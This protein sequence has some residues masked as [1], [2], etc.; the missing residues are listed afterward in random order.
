MNSIQNILLK[1]RTKH[2]YYNNIHNQLFRRKN[3][4]IKKGRPTFLSEFEPRS[5]VLN[6]QLHHGFLKCYSGLEV[7]SK[8]VISTKLSFPQYGAVP[9]IWE[10]NIESSILHCRLHVEQ[11]VVK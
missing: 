8:L 7:N 6:C 11:A 1:Q 9:S 10:I 5:L 2:L 4:Q 3:K